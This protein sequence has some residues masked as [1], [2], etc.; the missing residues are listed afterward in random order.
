MRQ[1]R[2]D[3][4]NPLN[5]LFGMTTVL[6]QTELS[7]MQAT[8]VQGCRNAAQQLLDIAHDLEAYQHEQPQ[9]HIDGPQQLADLCSIAVARVDKPFDRDTL[10]GVVRR[11]TREA[12]PRILLVDDAPD[13]AVLVNAYLKGTNC[14]LDV[15]GDGQRAVAQAASQPYDLVLMDVDLPGL[16]GATAAHA[17]RAAD[18]ARGA[19]P[20]PVVALSAMGTGLAPRES[21]DEEDRV[22]LDDPDTA[23]LVP[24]FLDNRRQDIHQMRQLLEHGDFARIQSVGHKMKGTG[25]SYGFTAISRIGADIERA[26]REQD[27][28]ALERLINDLNSFLSRVKIEGPS[29]RT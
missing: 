16:D 9:R 7:E 3:L 20:T 6:L 15:V 29:E 17:I 19:R 12:A 5:V 27:A 24:A 26:G 14:T 25:R 23:P 8:C 4:L 21:E 18:L 13:I 10:L 11:L 1:L 2:H 22:V 28:P